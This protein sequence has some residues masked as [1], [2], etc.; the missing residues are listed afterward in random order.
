MG[1]QP[2]VKVQDLGGNTIVGNSSGVTLALTVVGGATLACTTNPQGAV[3]GVASFAG[4]NVD[5]VNTYTLTA[6]DGSLTT[7]VSKEHHSETTDKTIINF[8]KQAVTWIW[9][10][11][12]QISVFRGDQTEISSITYGNPDMRFIPPGA[13]PVPPS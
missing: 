13:N 4:C 11:Q 2:V 10:R 5:K 9:V 12:T 6:S 7:A 1:T 8:A 3:G